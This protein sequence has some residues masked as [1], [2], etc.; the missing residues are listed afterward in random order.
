MQGSSAVFR[1]STVFE[2]PVLFSR[3]YA[4]YPPAQCEAIGAG[5]SIVCSGVAD[6]VLVPLESARDTLFVSVT[7]SGGIVNVVQF[8]V[9]VSSDMMLNRSWLVE[10]PESVRKQYP[11]FAFRSTL[12]T[13]AEALQL[14]WCVMDKHIH[15]DSIAPPTH[16]T[17]G[18]IFRTTLD[19]LSAAASARIE[20]G[21]RTVCGPTG[22][23]TVLVPLNT[24]RVE[25]TTNTDSA[26]V[27]ITRCG[28][29]IDF[30]LICMHGLSYSTRAK[31]LFNQS[32]LEREFPDFAFSNRNC[33]RFHQIR[34]LLLD[35]VSAHYGARLEAHMQERRIRDS[36]EAVAMGLHERLGSAALIASIGA[37]NLALV[38][39]LM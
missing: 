15:G 19:P 27:A 4:S 18:L 39:Q 21:L 17:T 30:S 36:L 26:F 29:E 23:L 7:Q 12:I 35:P 2:L 5:I 20:A 25:W 28:F 11:A 6:S 3:T 34:A 1:R 9:T 33:L 16:P 24:L 13:D 22:K 32:A 38:A 10:T 14:V 31:L 37:D 8:G